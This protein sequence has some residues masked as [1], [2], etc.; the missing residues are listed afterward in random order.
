MIAV[1]AQD[2][3]I[4]NAIGDAIAMKLIAK[5]CGGSQL[6][7][8]IFIVDRRAGKAKE[9]GMRK[10]SADLVAH[11]TEVRTVALIDDDD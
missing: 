3:V 11:L 7:F 8:L 10:S 9:N 2:I 1:K 4:A 5:Q 6:L